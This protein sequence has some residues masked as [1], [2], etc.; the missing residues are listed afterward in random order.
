M[1]DVTFWN[2]KINCTHLTTQWTTKQII[3]NKSY[4]TNF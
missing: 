1:N 4:F 2:E 3:I